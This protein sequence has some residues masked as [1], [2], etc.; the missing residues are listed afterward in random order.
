MYAQSASRACPILVS[1]GP[2]LRTGIPNHR[3]RLSFKLPLLKCWQCLA[4]YFYTFQLNNYF[5]THVRTV[6]TLYFLAWLHHN[7]TGMYVKKWERGKQHQQHI[8]IHL[9]PRR[10]QSKSDKQRTTYLFITQPLT[11]PARRDSNKKRATKSLVKPL[12]RCIKKIKYKQNEV[13]VS[14]TPI[15]LESLVLPAHC[16]SIEHCRSEWPQRSPPQHRLHAHYT[17]SIPSYPDAKPRRRIQSA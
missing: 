5:L 4:L 6:F 3:S 14:A 16:Q 10:L 17:T 15:Y 13:T 9:I 11:C 2:T 1:C 8:C 7:C 12:S